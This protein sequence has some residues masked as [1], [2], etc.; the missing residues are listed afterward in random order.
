MVDMVVAKILF[1]RD[2]NSFMY[3]SVY[4]YCC[5]SCHYAMKQEVNRD[6]RLARQRY[7]ASNTNLYPVRKHYDASY[8]WDGYLIVSKRFK[9]F[10]EEKTYQ[11]AI[12]H[13]IPKEP[14]FYFLE[15]AKIIP[16]DYVRRNVQFGTLCKVCNRY[17][18]IAGATPSYIQQG[19][20]ME[21]NTF[22]QSEH[23]FGSYNQKSPVIIIS[24]QMA[25][26]MSAQKFRGIFFLNVLE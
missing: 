5:D 16:L 4:P 2:N 18:Y 22:Y 13:S 3:D 8:T 10:C 25:K 7:D 6:F 9:Q 20:V 23:D 21:E 15:S 26:E 17:D 24:L 19:F 1:G 14:D 12:F 11:N